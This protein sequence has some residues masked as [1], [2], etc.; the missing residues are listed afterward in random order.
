MRRARFPVAYSEGFNP[1]PRMAFA[2]AL[3]LGATSQYELCQLD[4]AEEVGEDRLNEAVSALRAQMPA[5]ITVEEVWAVP[6]EKRSPYIQAVAA[7]YRLT[8]AGEDAADRTQRFLSENPERFSHPYR[9]E[10]QPDEAWLTIR[11]PVGERGG[12]RI[13]DVVAELEQ[14]LPGIEVTRLCRT[15]LWCEREPGPELQVRARENGPTALPHE[16]V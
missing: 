11:L 3:T 14:A 7:E 12:V 8:L 2:S 5:G 4:L 9:V 1:R 13:R 6:L 15:R 16:R 10:A